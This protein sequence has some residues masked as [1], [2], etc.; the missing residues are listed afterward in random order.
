M[1]LLRYVI[2]KLS[3]MYLH[4]HVFAQLNVKF[5]NDKILT[6]NRGLQGGLEKN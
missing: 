2:F 6:M 1:R 4:V 3:K 5:D